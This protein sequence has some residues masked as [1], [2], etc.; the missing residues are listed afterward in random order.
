MRIWNK[1]LILFLVSLSAGMAGNVMDDVLL[2]TQLNELEYIHH[3]DTI[4]Q[5][6]SAILPDLDK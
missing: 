2:L 3:R 1:S 5:R 4:V 6:G